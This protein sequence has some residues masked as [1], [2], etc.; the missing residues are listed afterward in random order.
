MHLL[1]VLQKLKTMKK[2]LKNLEALGK[3]EN[4]QNYP[5]HPNQIL[6]YNQKQYT[7]MT[8]DIDIVGKCL[9]EGELAA[10]A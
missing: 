8:V 2:K 6:Y 1:S 5:N 4:S 3:D 9:D 7:P 10:D